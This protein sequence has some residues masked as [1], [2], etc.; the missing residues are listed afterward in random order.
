[1]R[2]VKWVLFFLFI[3]GAILIIFHYG[4]CVNFS[5]NI[6]PILSVIATVISAIATVFLAVF[7]WRLFSA[8]KKLVDDGSDKS[9]KQLRAYVSIR[10][11]ENGCNLNQINFLIK[12]HGQTPANNVRHTSAVQILPRPLPNDFILSYDESSTNELKKDVHRD[13][14]GFALHPSEQINNWRAFDNTPSSEIDNLKA[15]RSA[16]YFYGVVEYEDM[17][18]EVH[19]SQYCIYIRGA[20]IAS[21][22]DTPNNVTLKAKWEY[23]DIGNIAN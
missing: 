12:N 19:K 8:T 20:I 18:R 5:N 23:A 22:A 2:A 4:S 3:I 17:F 21:L 7:T 16:L 11:A 13:K 6:A 14:G 15:D 10:P 9:E 1:M